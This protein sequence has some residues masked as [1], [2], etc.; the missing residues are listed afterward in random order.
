MSARQSKKPA[1]SPSATRMVAALTTLFGSYTLY[2]APQTSEPPPAWQSYKRT[3]ENDLERIARKSRTANTLYYPGMIVAIPR[4]FYIDN[5]PSDFSQSYATRFAPSLKDPR[6][7]KAE[8]EKTE[9][10]ETMQRKL[11]EL[12]SM[13]RIKSRDDLAAP[14]VSYLAR[15]WPLCFSV[16]VDSNSEEQLRKTTC[17]QKTLRDFSLASGAAPS[18]WKGS[19]LFD[20]VFPELKVALPKITTNLK[21]KTGLPWSDKPI[22]LSYPLPRSPYNLNVH[23]AGNI[24][25]VCNQWRVRLSRRYVHDPLSSSHIAGFDFNI[26]HN[27]RTGEIHGGYTPDSP[28][29]PKLDPYRIRRECRTHP[30][31]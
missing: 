1:M 19:G 7:R 29:E 31:P 23:F 16:V 26:I 17:T 24:R 6:V 20:E 8:E 15:E 18:Y 25:D 4:N 22:V 14:L 3:L 13:I 30:V 10:R 28:Q 2:S 12:A 5:A 9:K 21:Q 11:S 27:Y